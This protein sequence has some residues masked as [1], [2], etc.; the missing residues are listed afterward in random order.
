MGDAPRQCGYYHQNPTR[1]SCKDGFRCPFQHSNHRN[2]PGTE[3]RMRTQRQVQ[4]WA[5]GHMQGASAA[6]AQITTGS[7]PV[8]GLALQLLPRVLPGWQNNSKDMIEKILHAVELGLANAELPRWL[9]MVRGVYHSARAVYSTSSRH[10]GHAW[11]SVE[12]FEV[13]AGGNYLRSLRRILPICTSTLSGQFVCNLAQRIGSA[14]SGPL[15]LTHLGAGPRAT[16]AQ[17]TQ[18]AGGGRGD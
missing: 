12:A 13:A 1:D 4:P 14:V 5:G 17:G 7:S 16:P 6:A 18:T 9:H 15:A 3:S 11:F 10:F 8:L 2:R